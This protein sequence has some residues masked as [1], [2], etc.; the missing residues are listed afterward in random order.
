[1]IEWSICSKEILISNGW[2]KHLTIG[3]CKTVN[4]LLSGYTLIHI[5]NRETPG[6]VQRGRS[7]A[8]VELYTF[9]SED[10][11]DGFF[12]SD[13]RSP[14]SGDSEQNSQGATESNDNSVNMSGIYFLSH[15]T[16]AHS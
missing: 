8:R 14:N 4:I 16:H 10:D 6:L 5:R 7:R 13:E 11:M 12:D 2:T 15:S 3:S 1:M 9:D